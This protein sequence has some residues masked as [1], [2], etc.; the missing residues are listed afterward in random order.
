MAVLEEADGCQ[1]GG[2]RIF[3]E[4]KCGTRLAMR[5]MMLTIVC[6]YVEGFESSVWVGTRS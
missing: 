1:V 2:H 4:D 5:L 3:P 6:C